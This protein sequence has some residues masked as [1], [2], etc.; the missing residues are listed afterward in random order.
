M[1]FLDYHATRGDYDLAYTVLLLAVVVV[2]TGLVLAGVGLLL[3]MFL[4]ALVGVGIA[5]ATVLG[6]ALALWRILNRQLLER[7][8]RFTLVVMAGAFAY[9][10]L[11]TVA[12]R[13][14]PASRT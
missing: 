9:S 5:G 3:R 11:V 14:P 7:G 1:P 2:V 4:L 10:F 8:D 6:V 13:R 12:W